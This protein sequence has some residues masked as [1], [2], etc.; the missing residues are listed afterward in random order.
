METCENMPSGNQQENED[1]GEPAVTNPDMNSATQVKNPK[2][3]SSFQQ[4]DHS[5]SPTSESSQ[6][7]CS[8]CGRICKCHSQVDID[9]RLIKGD[10]CMECVNNFSPCDHLCSHQKTHTKEKPYQCM[11]CG[12]SFGYSSNLRRHKMIHTGEKP[13]KCMECGKCFRE[14]G[15]LGRHLKIHTGEKPFKCMECGKSF[16]LKAQLRSHQRTHTGEKPYKCMECGKGFSDNRT[17]DEP[18]C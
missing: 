15:S 6:T 4:D 10:R 2:T 7:Q 14:S 17:L 12:K 13:H 3:L 9:A 11:D 5:E 8:D 1:H 18:A 16:I